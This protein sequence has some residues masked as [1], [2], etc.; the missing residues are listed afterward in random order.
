VMR[1]ST[2][3]RQRLALIRLL[4]GQ[5][6][7]LLLDEPTASLDEKNVQAVEALVKEYLLA[8]G[9]VIWVSHDSNQ[10]QRVADRHYRITGNQLQ[11]V[12]S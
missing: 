6:K 4:C 1:C 11:E 12:S 2:G 3:E 8:G 10:I 9:V 5:P 7:V